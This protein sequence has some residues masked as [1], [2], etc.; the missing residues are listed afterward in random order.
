[1][2]RAQDLFRWMLFSVHPLTVRELRDVS[3]P[4]WQDGAGVGRVTRAN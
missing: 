3:Q 4:R 2:Q 1:M